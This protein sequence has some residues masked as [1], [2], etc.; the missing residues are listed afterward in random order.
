MVIKELKFV[1]A[2][3][4]PG[5]KLLGS[6]GTLTSLL[7]MFT[8]SCTCKLR[9]QDLNSSQPH[10]SNFHHDCLSMRMLP[11]G[12]V[13]EAEVR[14]SVSIINQ[15]R[16]ISMHIIHTIWIKLHDLP[17]VIQNCCFYTNRSSLNRCTTKYHYHN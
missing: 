7:N 16:Y 17:L 3:N 2:D 13:T 1:A 9:A 5:L 4:G 10:C 8:T 6:V 15:L 11:T 12:S 14:R